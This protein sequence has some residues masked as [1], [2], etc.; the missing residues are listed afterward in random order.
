K[1]DEL[2]KSSSSLAA[3]QLNSLTELLKASEEEVF[4]IQGLI[5][6]AS[7][8]KDPSGATVLQPNF[9]DFDE[10]AI[11]RLKA[12]RLYHLQNLDMVYQQSIKDPKQQV[13]G[14]CFAPACAWY[15]GSTVEE[16]GHLELE[17]QTIG[18]KYG[19]QT[20]S[21]RRFDDNTNSVEITK[22]AHTDLML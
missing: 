8:K 17:M 3:G 13:A 12:R 21:D 5:Q 18:E 11:N 22:E 16:K 7:Q 2:K 6:K 15:V 4:S 1:I 20:I 19:I 10:A 9:N 14:K